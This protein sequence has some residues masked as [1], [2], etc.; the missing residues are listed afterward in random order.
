MI[1]V[2]SAKIEKSKKKKKAKTSV[3]LKRLDKN[4]QKDSLLSFPM[5][6]HV[7]YYG[8]GTALALDWVYMAF[9]RLY[10][11]YSLFMSCLHLFSYLLCYFVLAASLL[12]S[13]TRKLVY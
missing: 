2:E 6:L 9:N 8:L 11:L 1:K 12:Y 5:S 4:H 7:L 13:T 3:G 10:S